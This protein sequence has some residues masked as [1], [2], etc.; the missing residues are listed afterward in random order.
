MPANKSALLRYRIIDSCLTNK[1]KPYPTLEFIQEKIQD[2]LDDEI[3]IS[4]INKDFAEM[5]KIYDAPIKYCR[6]NKGY[7]YTEPG[8]SIREFPL[9]HQEIEALDF[10][11]ALL[12]QLKG[13]K[14]LERFENAINK[15]IE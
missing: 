8:F 13:T 9:T 14:L 7:H 6:S 5:K 15:V 3:S 4:M 2:Q 10:S 11:T 12:N 1:Q